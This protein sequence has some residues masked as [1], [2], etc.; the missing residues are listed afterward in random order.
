[1]MW[2]TFFFLPTLTPVVAAAVLWRWMLQPE[3]GL[4]NY[5]L[6]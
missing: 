6:A 2:R 3:V 1:M 4:V 5:L